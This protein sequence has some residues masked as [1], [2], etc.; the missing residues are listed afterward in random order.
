M[1][2]AAGV[3]FLFN[4]RLLKQVDGVATGSPLCTSLANFYLSYLEETQFL[5]IQGSNQSCTLDMWMT[6]LLFSTRI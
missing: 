3:M 5:I 1:K 4:D 2:F 6:F